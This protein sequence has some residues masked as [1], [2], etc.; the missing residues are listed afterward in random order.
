MQPLWE[1]AESIALWIWILKKALVLY[2]F[3][4]LKN[5]NKCLLTRE[6]GD[7]SAQKI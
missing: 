1:N 4:S 6:A 5:V 2:D 7:G 3:N